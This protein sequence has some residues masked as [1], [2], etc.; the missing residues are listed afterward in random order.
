[1][2][3]FNQFDPLDTNESN[4][5]PEEEQIEA[6]DD[7]PEEGISKSVVEPSPKKS[8]LAT[9]LLDYIEIFVVAISI[10]ILLFSFV[11]RICSV[12]GESM[13]DTLFN[14]EALVVS[15]L[16]YTPDEGDVIVFHQTGRLNEPVVKRVIA[17]AGET[18]HIEYVSGG[19][20][21]TVT[22][23]NGNKTELIEDYIKYVDVP[24]YQSSE[25]YHVGE[26]QLFVM[27]DN[28][29]H[30]KDSR[31]PDIGLVDERRVLGKVLFRLTPISRFGSVD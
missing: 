25:T 20:K 27:G 10:V 29:N 30:S 5:I 8:K 24:L 11:F 19:M 26:G 13:E 18:V 12:T 7:L 1:M 28:R 15:N 16:F 17:T 14:R 9:E 23:I 3:D 22:D 4:G 6:K 2:S 21:V 31:H